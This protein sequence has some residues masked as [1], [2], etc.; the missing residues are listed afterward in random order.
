MGHVEEPERLFDSVTA[1]LPVLPSLLRAVSEV[2]RAEILEEH[3]A[4]H[5]E[6]LVEDRP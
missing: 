1:D 2:K 6:A 4:T 3:I 5:G